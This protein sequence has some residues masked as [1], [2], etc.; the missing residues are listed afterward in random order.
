MHGL[1]NSEEVLVAWEVGGESIRDDFESDSRGRGG[2][3]IV[4]GVGGEGSRE[5]HKS[6]GE[7]CGEECFGEE[8]GAIDV[9]E[10]RPRHQQRMGGGHGLHLLWSTLR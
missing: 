2:E 6:D 10:A 7:A 1:G 3:A 9:A 5:I 8:H 4:G